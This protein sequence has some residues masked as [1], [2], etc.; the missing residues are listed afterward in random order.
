[1]E[2]EQLAA[3]DPRFI[4]DEINALVK[5]ALDESLGTSQFNH[6]KIGNWTSTVCEACMKR[7]TSLDKPFKYAVTCVIM[8]KNGAGLVT[9]TSCF[10][11][12]STDGSRTIRWENKTMYCIV[13]VFGMA[14]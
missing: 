6:E 3:V 1:M 5:A 4:Q 12:V 9:A 2:P 7:L 8:Q 13:T 14:I 11:D 10:W